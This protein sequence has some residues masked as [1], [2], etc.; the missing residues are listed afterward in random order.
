M[1]VTKFKRREPTGN[2]LRLCCRRNLKRKTESLNSITGLDATNS[3]SSISFF[4]LLSKTV[5]LNLNL[6]YLQE[7]ILKAFLAAE[8]VGFSV[9]NDV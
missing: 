8:M 7:K 9:L 6:K 4:I 3:F 1:S 5:L 2:I